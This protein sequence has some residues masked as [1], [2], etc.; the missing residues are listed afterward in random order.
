MKK[1]NKGKIKTK[2]SFI[3]I[4]NKKE[5]KVKQKNNPWIAH[6]KAFRKSN[7]KLSLVQALKE[8]KKTYK[9]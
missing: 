3:N 4:K 1:T 8:A 6:V 5:V 7:P 9:K 2:R